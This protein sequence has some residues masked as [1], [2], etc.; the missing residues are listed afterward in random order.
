MWD[1]KVWGG[2]VWGS[3]MWGGEDSIGATVAVGSGLH[4]VH[5]N[6]YWIVILG[7]WL[8]TRYICM[9]LEVTRETVVLIIAVV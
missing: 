7:Q 4:N 2:K 6:D 3:R 8:H 5:S 1:G 9:C